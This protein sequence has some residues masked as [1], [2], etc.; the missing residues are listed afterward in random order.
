MFPLFS[1][2]SVKELVKSVSEKYDTKVGEK[3]F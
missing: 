2:V 1:E 3:S